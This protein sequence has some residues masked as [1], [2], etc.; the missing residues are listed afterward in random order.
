MQLGA[1]V[2]TL[3]TQLAEQQSLGL[4]QDCPSDV[5]PEAS[6]AASIAEPDGPSRSASTATLVAS[7]EAAPSTL[8]SGAAASIAIVPSMPASLGS[9]PGAAATSPRLKWTT[10]A[11]IA[12]PTTIPPRLSNPEPSA[13]V[14]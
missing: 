9:A 2:H 11:S 6:M 13:L 5:H 4:A 1:L 14:Q 3:L 7:M 8:A 10:G 12:P